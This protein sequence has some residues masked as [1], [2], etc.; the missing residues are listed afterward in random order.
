MMVW[1]LAKGKAVPLHR[2]QVG[3]HLTQS[4]IDPALTGTFRMKL[5][6]GREV[7]VMPIYQMYTIHLQDYDLDT[8]HQ[9][10]RAPKDLFV[11]WARDC[12]TVKP[13]AIHNGE[14]VCHYF[15]M[16]AMGRAAALVMMHDRQY[17]EVRHGLSYLVRQL[18]GRHLEAA[19]WSGAGASVYIGE[20]PCNLNLREDA[21]GKEIKYPQIL[22]W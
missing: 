4:G 21:H 7:D 16:T 17:R 3:M 8:V 22:L 10:N 9:V 18:Q 19:P 20:D 15:H 11:R 2:E 5:L 6:N 12:G 13:A 1:D 14:G